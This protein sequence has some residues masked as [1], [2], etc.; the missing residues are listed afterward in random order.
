MS[1]SGQQSITVTETHNWRPGMVLFL[2]QS[3]YALFGIFVGTT[4]VL[5]AEIMRALGIGTGIFGTA[6][7]T[8]QH[9]FWSQTSD[10][11]RPGHLCQCHSCFGQLG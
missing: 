5:W 6:M 9:A 3:Y 1:Q 4:G 8:T 10:V 11:G 7:R 2:L